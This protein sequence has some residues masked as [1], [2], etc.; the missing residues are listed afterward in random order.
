[1][2]INLESHRN[3]EYD[4]L[5]IYDGR[6][7]QFLLGKYCD[8]LNIGPIVAHSGAMTIVFVSD[9]RNTER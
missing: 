6:S 4:Y 2:N 7:R 5:S 8:D 1:M 9:E 3:C